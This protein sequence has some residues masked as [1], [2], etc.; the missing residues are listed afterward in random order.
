M[1]M[2]HSMEDETM[3][4]DEINENVENDPAKYD[5]I[6]ELAILQ[7][8]AKENQQKAE[9]TV[10]ASRIIPAAPEGTYLGVT[11]NALFEKN[12]PS[13][14]GTNDRIKV[15]YQF[16]NPAASNE[17]IKMTAIY[18]LSNSEKSQYYRYLS[19]LLQKDPRKGFHIKELIGITCEVEIT[20]NPVE[21]GAY[22][23]ITNVKQIDVDENGP[24]AL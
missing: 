24:I 4:N 7:A 18:W 22:A 9:A 14:Y 11:T 16:I 23:N 20:H 6:A 2:N 5:A 13:K 17:V 8:Q 1:K 21:N 10:N 3:K 19:E 12:L 15:D